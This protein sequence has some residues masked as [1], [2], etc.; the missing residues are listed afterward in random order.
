VWRAVT[1]PSSWRAEKS[2]LLRETRMR[3]GGR[4][5]SR[6]GLRCDVWSARHERCGLRAAATPLRSPHDRAPR[7]VTATRPRRRPPPTYYC[8][9][10]GQP[11]ALFATGPA[12]LALV[13]QLG[14]S[15]QGFVCVGRCPLGYGVRCFENIYIYIYIYNHFAKLYDRLKIYQTSKVYVWH[16]CILKILIKHLF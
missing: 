1:S 5:G 13:G 8:S 9:T 11:R 16:A 10:W 7:D 15:Y 12:L 6:S 14:L 3:T 2:D 4:G